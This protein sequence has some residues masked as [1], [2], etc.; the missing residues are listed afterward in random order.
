MA[1]SIISVAMLSFHIA[2][3][4]ARKIGVCQFTPTCRKEDADYITTS[5]D[6]TR[7]MPHLILAG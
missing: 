5:I 1:D 6:A 4:D 3:S 7:S 2:S